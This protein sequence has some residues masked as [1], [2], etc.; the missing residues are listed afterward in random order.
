MDCQSPD[1]AFESFMRIYENFLMNKKGI[2]EMQQKVEGE[3]K[4]TLDTQ[5]TYKLED[6][7]KFIE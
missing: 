3:E 7:I 2:I 4:D 1:N 5:I 6:V